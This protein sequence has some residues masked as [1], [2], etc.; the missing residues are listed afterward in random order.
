[1]KPQ[2]LVAQDLLNHCSSCIYFIIMLKWS[3]SKI[4]KFENEFGAK[5]N[6]IGSRKGF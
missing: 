3:S 1:M 5:I 2:G 4:D 6:V